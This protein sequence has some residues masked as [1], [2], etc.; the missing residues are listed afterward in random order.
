[1]LATL[2]CTLIGAAL[3]ALALR[4]IFD[5]LFHPEG[6]SRLSRFIARRTWGA[7]SSLTRT[8]QGLAVAG[9]LAVFAVI[10]AWALLFVLA[11]ALIYL[12]HVANAFEAPGGGLPRGLGSRCA[13]AVAFSLQVL[14]TL[15]FSD[16]VPEAPWLRILAPFEALIGFGLLSASISWLLTAQPVLARRRELAYELYLAM[17]TAGFDEAAFA[18][19]VAML[20]RELVPRLVVVERDLVAFPVTFYFAVSDERFSLAAALP[21]LERARTRLER[22]RTGPAEVR[23]HV[24]VLGEA[25]DDLAATIATHLRVA[26]LGTAAVFDAYA[27]AHRV[28]PWIGA[29]QRHR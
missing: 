3:L 12:P 21:A 11:F 17:R 1:V 13:E 14:T 4:D 29:G 22:G 6:N 19:D 28:R 20:V 8:R 18:N 5:S 9:P 15:G 23:E 26:G 2:A 16:L 27:R 24:R 25:L 10:G 7:V